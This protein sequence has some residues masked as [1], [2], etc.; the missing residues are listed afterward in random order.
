MRLTARKRTKLKKRTMLKGGSAA[1]DKLN[2]SEYIKQKYYELELEFGLDEI[3]KIVEIILEKYNT[4][5]LTLDECER[6]TDKLITILISPIQPHSSPSILEVLSKNDDELKE[7]YKEAT[8]N[9]PKEET[10]ILTQI[11]NLKSSDLDQS[12]SNLK[13]LYSCR[14][15]DS[16]RQCYLKSSAK[17]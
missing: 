2:I 10:D 13:S 7:L 4:T 1:Q 3:T 12:S 5:T 16:T 15:T 8:R 17:V 9:D 6:L 14:C 11:L